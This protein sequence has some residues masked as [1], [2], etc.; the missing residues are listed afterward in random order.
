MPAY[1]EDLPN[2]SYQSFRTPPT[3]E[4]FLE[5]LRFKSAT[6]IFHATKKLD[7]VGTRYQ[8]ISDL[9]IQW[10]DACAMMESRGFLG[11]ADLIKVMGMRLGLQ[12]LRSTLAGMPGYADIIG[13][14]KALVDGVP[15]NPKLIFGGRG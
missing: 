11:K 15:K 9:A 7:D 6:P 1:E 12:Q 3:E 10:E 13:E 14:I 2:E 5:Q 8:H 4:D